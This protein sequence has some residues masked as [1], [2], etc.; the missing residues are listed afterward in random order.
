MDGIFS[1]GSFDNGVNSPKMEYA[2]V[3]GSVGSY[4]LLRSSRYGFYKV[5]NGSQM[6]LPVDVFDL[7]SLENARFVISRTDNCIYVA[8]NNNGTQ[9]NLLGLITPIVV[10]ANVDDTHTFS[11]TLDTDGKL[12][13][14]SKNLVLTNKEVT[15]SMDLTDIYTKLGL[16]DST[17]FSFSE[18]GIELG[19]SMLN[20]PNMYATSCVVSKTSVSFYTRNITSNTTENI[21][22]KYQFIRRINQ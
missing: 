21:S 13:A 10:T 22:S 9:F 6:G 19:K 11:I 18:I 16:S 3:D 2:T 12:Y 5:T 20:T 7:Y 8:K 4:G 1:V 17:Q 15:I 14:H